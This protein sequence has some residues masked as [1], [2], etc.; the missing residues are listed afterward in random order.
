MVEK[1]KSLLLLLSRDQMDGHYK[2]CLMLIQPIRESINKLTLQS[3]IR[4]YESNIVYS[5]IVDHGDEV[6][7]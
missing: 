2:N 4:F 7:F 3:I 5:G 6:T 1:Y